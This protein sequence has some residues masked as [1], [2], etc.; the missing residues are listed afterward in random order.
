MIICPDRGRGILEIKTASEY[1]LHEW[2]NDNIP[3]YYYVQLQWYLFVTG[4]EWGYFATLI[5][6]NKYREYEVF[7]D[8]ELIEQLSRL[9]SDFWQHYVLLSKAPPI[10]GSAAATTLLNRLY[11][12]SKNSIIISINEINEINDLDKYFEYKQQLKIVEENINEIENKIKSVLGIHEIGRIGN[13]KIKWENRS[14]TGLDS[15][16]LKA[17]YPDIYNQFLKTTH[18]RQFSVKQE[19]KKDE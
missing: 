15:K 2:A 14:R 3:D 18:F 13:Y 11:P 19:A 6:G 12:A 4:L 9:A 1:L 5:G 7:R 17:D 8:N 10:D 16:Q